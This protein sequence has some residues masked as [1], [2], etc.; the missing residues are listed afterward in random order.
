[1][2]LVDRRDEMEMSELVE[3]LELRFPEKFA[4]FERDHPEALQAVID[5]DVAGCEE[6]LLSDLH[7]NLVALLRV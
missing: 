5:D 4:E 2:T 7:D 1:M 6:E 3:E